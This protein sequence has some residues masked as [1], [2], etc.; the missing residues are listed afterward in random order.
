MRPW[1][2]TQEAVAV[3]SMNWRKPRWNQHCRPNQPSLTRCEI[4]EATTFSYGPVEAKLTGNFNTRL[5]STKFVPHILATQ[6]KVTSLFL[7]T[8]LI[9]K[10]QIQHV[11]QVIMG[12]ESWVYGF[13]PE[14]KT[15]APSGRR[16]LVLRPKNSTSVKIAREGHNDCFL[17]HRKNDAENFFP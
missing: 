11:S 6:R 7:P 5:V 8:C 2:M 17:C 14:L 13:D 1:K 10:F 16:P 12:D 15:R 4:M 9:N 3:N